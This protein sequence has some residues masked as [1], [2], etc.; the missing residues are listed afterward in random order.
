MHAWHAGLHATTDALHD[1][2]GSRFFR[3]LIGVFEGHIGRSVV[4]GG[5]GERGGKQPDATTPRSCSQHERRE[6]KVKSH[7]AMRRYTWLARRNL[8]W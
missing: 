5:Y 8:G 6:K 7:D 3:R 1:F 2:A 4:L